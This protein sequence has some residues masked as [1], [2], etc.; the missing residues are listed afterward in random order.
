MV[1][2]FNSDLN[3]IKEF[4]EAKGYY[5][6]L[7]RT[8]KD[9]FN[10]V[11]EAH[12]GLYLFHAQNRI[13]PKNSVDTGNFISKEYTGTIWIAKVSDLDGVIHNDKMVEVERI[14]SMQIDQDLNKYF[15]KED[16]IQVSNGRPFYDLFSTNY[17][18]VMFDYSITVDE[19]FKL[20]QTIKDNY[21]RNG[22]FS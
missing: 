14:L 10:L 20:N 15:C 5:Y 22:K 13:N 16:N 2:G 11:D 9:F 19:N 8:S 12:Q 18:G 4:A 17:D 21:I 3:L 6:Y 1:N 7:A